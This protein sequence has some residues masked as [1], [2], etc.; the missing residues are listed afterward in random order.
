MYISVYASRIY[1]VLCFC[2]FVA[3][4]RYQSIIHGDKVTILPD[5]PLHIC[6]RLGCIVC[7]LMKDL[8]S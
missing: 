2:G 3:S 7:F 8:S 5:A 1:F 4:N 6:A